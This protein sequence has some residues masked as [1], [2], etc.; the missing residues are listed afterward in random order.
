MGVKISFGKKP[1][2]P[3]LKKAV[4]QVAAVFTHLGAQHT[5]ATEALAEIHKLKKEGVVGLHLY[6]AMKQKGYGWMAS[7][8]ACKAV[9][10]LT[11]NALNIAKK[12][13]KKHGG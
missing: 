9:I 1:E 5:K 2:D 4:A 3:E 11:T 8:A 10:E 6:E 13:A 7:G 12:T